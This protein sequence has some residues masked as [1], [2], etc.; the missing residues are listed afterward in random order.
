MRNNNTGCATVFRSA[1]QGCKPASAVQPAAAVVVN[2]SHR[3]L[4]GHSITMDGTMSAKKFWLVMRYTRWLLWL[5][6]LA[7]SLEFY[8]HRQ[9]HMY[10]GQLLPT[11]EAWMFGLG[12]AS[13]TAGLVELRT[14]DK[15]GIKREPDNKI[16]FDR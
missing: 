3:G 15:A 1:R 11:T 10:L 16:G 2:T 8:V 13:V 7:Y 5:A 4:A 14:R 12:L 9:Q 6:F